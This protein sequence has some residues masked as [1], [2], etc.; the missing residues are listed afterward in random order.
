MYAYDEST[1]KIVVSRGHS[2]RMVRKTKEMIRMTL[3]NGKIVEST[4]EHKF[5]DYDKKCMVEAKD[6]HEGSSLLPIRFSWTNT[7]TKVSHPYGGS[8][9]RI[10]YLADDYNVKIGKYTVD[11]GDHRHHIDGNIFNNNP[12]NIIRMNGKEHLAYHRRENFKD[13]DYRDNI[14]NSTI[15]QWK[16]RREEMLGYASKGGKAYVDKYNSDPEHIL[17]RMKGQ[18]AKSYCVCTNRIQYFEQQCIAV[19]SYDWDD[20]CDEFINDGST[21][22]GKVRTLIS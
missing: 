8:K 7:Y 11:S 2:A 14:V 13:T 19:C 21:G 4:P 1:E 5:F 17:L 15:N 6:L 10:Y 12:T 3:D 20:K 16:T 22:L 18:K 9:S